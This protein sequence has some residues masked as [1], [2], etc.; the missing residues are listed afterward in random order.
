MSSFNTTPID[1]PSVPKGDIQSDSDHIGA[2][3]TAGKKAPREHG[4]T[5]V[6]RRLTDSGDDATLRPVEEK[7]DGPS[8]PEEPSLDCFDSSG[9]EIEEEFEEPVTAQTGS[10]AETNQARGER[11]KNEQHVTSG[12]EKGVSRRVHTFRNRI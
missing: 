1:P 2:G 11:N 10:E 9:S 7:M 3:G 8:P 4:A 12:G 5:H 6:K